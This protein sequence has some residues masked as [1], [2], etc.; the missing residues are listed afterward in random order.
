MRLLGRNVHFPG[1]EDMCKDVW[2]VLGRKGRILHVQ[3]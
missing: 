1:Q 3:L 2:Q